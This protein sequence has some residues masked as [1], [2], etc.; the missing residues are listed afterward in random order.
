MSVK[1]GL[2]QSEEY[3]LLKPPSDLSKK[4][5][6]LSP[7][8]AQK[9]NPVAA[10]E[11]AVGKLSIQ[12]SGW[13]EKEVKDLVTAWDTILSQ[14]FTEANFEA[15]FCSV[16]DLKGQS[17][18]L[19]YPLI[20]RAARNLSSLLYYAKKD[21]SFPKELIGQNI[22]AIRAMVNEDAKDETNALGLQ[23]VEQLENLIKS[24]IREYN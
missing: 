1:N 17:E 19:G 14:G 4:V 24:K 16:H 23:L 12:F 9:F 15:L 13:M 21:N 2:P 10:A 22:D 6:Q 8:E 7:I 20:G 3:E 18:T 5:R 11:A